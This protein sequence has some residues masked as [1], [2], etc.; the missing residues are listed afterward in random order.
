MFAEPVGI[1]LCSIFPAV[2]GVGESPAGT[3]SLGAEPGAA[4]HEHATSSYVM[5]LVRVLPHISREVFHT[6]RR[7]ATGVAVHV[8]GQAIAPGST[9]TAAKISPANIRSGRGEPNMSDPPA[10]IITP[11]ELSA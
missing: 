8:F 9:A 5:K 6:E 10:D 3:F 11:T 2:G 1:A 7:C 4:A